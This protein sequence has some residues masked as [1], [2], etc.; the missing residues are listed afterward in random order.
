MRY[1][2]ED[3][4]ATILQLNSQRQSAKHIGVNS[5]SLERW[6]A[7]STPK[8]SSREKVR[9]AAAQIRRT[10]KQRAKQEKYEPIRT[11]VPVY[12]E[13]RE[14]KVY[15]KKGNDTGLY[16]PSEWVNYR[17]DRLNFEQCLDI[18]K[19]FR[20]QYNPRQR[21]QFIFMATD[22]T[23]SDGA[24]YARTGEELTDDDDYEGEQWT[25]HGSTIEMVYGKPD[26]ELKRLLRTY[27]KGYYRPGRIN[28]IYICVIVT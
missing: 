20:D 24:R 12:G 2:F 15:D 19:Q 14:L 11:K 6:L 21:V 16:K 1:S 9:A 3:N 5:R 18:L 13:R 10:L 7:G 22:D 28:I 23:E 4:L 8:A 26:S 27:Y 25:R 17:V